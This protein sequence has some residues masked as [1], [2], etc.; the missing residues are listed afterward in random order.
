MMASQKV[1][2]MKN[3]KNNLLKL[4]KDFS[5]DSRKQG[6]LRDR[7]LWEG[8]DLIARLGLDLIK[9]SLLGTWITNLCV[10]S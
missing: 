7:L 3:R 1:R 2:K 5:A 6:F 10:Y 9:M 8:L 4:L